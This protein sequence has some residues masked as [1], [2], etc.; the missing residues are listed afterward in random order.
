MKPAHSKKTMLNAPPFNAEA[1][2]LDA[3]VVSG[4]H[5]AKVL[6]RCT[7]ILRDEGLRHPFLQ[8]EQG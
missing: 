7:F 5:I 3:D 2:G 8:V 1:K 4:Y 6:S